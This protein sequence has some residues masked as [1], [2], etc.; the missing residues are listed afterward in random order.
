MSSPATANR[1]LAPNPS[2]SSPLIPNS[3]LHRRSPLA[4]AQRSWITL[5]E[6][7]LLFEIRHVAVVS[8]SEE[9]RQ[10]YAS[11]HPDPAASPKIPIL[12]DGPTKLI[13]SLVVMEYLA[14]QY[15]D[16][17][18]QVLPASAAATAM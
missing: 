6:K 14:S 3:T 11:I 13:E 8:E 1:R 18:T 10:L 5:L 4:A 15:A 12:I 16:S 7:Q 2:A 17:G 9:V